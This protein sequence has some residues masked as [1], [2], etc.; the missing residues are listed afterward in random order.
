MADGGEGTLDVIVGATQGRVDVVTVTGPLGAPVEARLGIVGGGATAI[1]EMAQAS[2]LGLVPLGRRDPL[3]T[4]SRGTGELIRAALDRGVGRIVV[5]VGGSATND[6]GAGA[7]QALGMALLDAAGESVG[8]GG[9]ALAR[10]AR[11]DLASLDSRLRA[12][13][14]DVAC[15]VTNPLVGPKG[16]SAVFGPQKGAS[17]DDRE[18]SSTRTSASSPKSSVA[19][20]A[21]TLRRFRAPARPGVWA[22]PSSLAEAACCGVS[23]WS[24]TS[25]GSTR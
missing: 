23:T 12:T 3:Q 8:P 1:V 22:P 21:S 17:P 18:R 5:A 19:T 20:R 9:G 16:A 11:I 6:A 10:L 7:L 24:S 2:G 15:D 4:T 25:W 14:L 13:Q